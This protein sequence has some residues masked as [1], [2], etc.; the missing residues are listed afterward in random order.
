[1]V[2]QKSA[3][4]FDRTI[5]PCVRVIG[6]PASSRAFSDPYFNFRA[7]KLIPSDAPVIYCLVELTYPYLRQRSIAIQH[8]IWWD[9]EFPTWKRFIIEKV[10]ERAL[11][12]TRAIVC[13]D[14]NY[15]N[16]ALGVLPDYASVTA[17]CHYV[18]NFV[19]GD[20]FQG[21]DVV[22]AAGARALNVLFPRRCEP[23]RG[24][25]LFLESCIKL[26]GEGRDFRATFC[27]WGSMQ[28][29]ITSAV[30]AHGYA[31]RVQVTD[32]SFDEMPE[33]Y[34]QADLVV[35][36][37]VRHEGTSLSCVEA[38]YMGKPVLATYIGGL[39][40]LILPGVNGELAPPTVDGIAGSMARL[41]DDSQLRSRYGESA[42]ELAKGFTLKKWS[43]SLWQVLSTSLLQN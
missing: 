37:T 38:L 21:D 36:P 5:R 16:W 43:D 28:Q 2:I 17:K 29:Q 40:N 30:A 39:P 6:V 25:S 42:R 14:T 33:A 18:P 7:H 11:R 32:V 27:G 9:G 19:D 26:W 34:R 31:D 12:Q 8:G 20:I 23:K 10:N 15:I 35:I 24:A 13:V 4:A 22:P 3:V 41:L 1:M